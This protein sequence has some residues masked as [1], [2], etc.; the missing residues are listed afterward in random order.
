MGTTNTNPKEQSDS[1]SNDLLDSDT[2]DPPIVADG[3]T[4]DGAEGND[5]QQ[6]NCSRCGRTRDVTHTAEA[7]TPA[8]DY[9]GLRGSSTVDVCSRCWSR[10]PE[11]ISENEDFDLPNFDRWERQIT[12]DDSKFVSSIWQSGCHTVTLDT[13]GCGRWTVSWFGEDENSEQT[14]EW[15]FGYRVR[16]SA[17]DQVQRMVRLIEL[18]AI[19][20]SQKVKTGRQQDEEVARNRGEEQSD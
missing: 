3:R 12:A 10:L 5:T 13:V 20:V 9:F 18:G 19:S 6:I 4:R 14:D 16:Q 17:L 1:Q 11:T 2:S 15:H 7:G 8:G